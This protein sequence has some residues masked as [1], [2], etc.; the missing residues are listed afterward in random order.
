MADKPIEIFRELIW[1]SNPAWF[2]CEAHN[3][4]QHLKKWREI[5]KDPLD[6]DPSKWSKAC[7]KMG[8]ERVDF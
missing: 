8:C 2:D 1:R 6:V 4:Q 3:T 7:E 5:M